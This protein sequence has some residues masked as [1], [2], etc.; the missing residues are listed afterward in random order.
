[1]GNTTTVV[2]TE[3]A[4]GPTQRGRRA[5][6]LVAWCLGAIWAYAA[7]V[8]VITPEGDDRSRRLAWSLAIVIA[9]LG[10]LGVAR[11]AP[12]TLRGASM[13][14]VGFAMIPVLLGAVAERLLR[15]PTLGDV[16]GL[17]AGIAG[18]V[19]IVQ[20][21]RLA[22]GAIRR[23]WVRV[24]AAL[25]G[26]FLVLQF[27]VVPATWAVIATNRA[28][29][30]SS[31]RTLADAGIAYQDVRIDGNGDYA[32]AAWWVP[33]RNRGAVIVLPGSGS[34]RD[35][36]IDHAAVV[37]N[38]GYGALL[39]D[40]AGHGDSDGRLMDFG[41]GS[42]LDVSRA[43]TWVLA[44][45][46][47]ERV[48]LLGLSMGGEVA[49]TTAGEDPRIAAVVAEG[50]TAR[51]WDDVRQLPESN[52]IATANSW[53]EF[54][55]TNLLAGTDP[56]IPLIRAVEQIDA[57][58]LLIAGNAP[59]E[60]SLD[61]RYAAAAP[62]ATLWSLADSGHIQALSTHPD[63]YRQRVLDLFARTLAG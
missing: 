62:D 30:V 10:A 28:R 4:V 33:S 11:R 21:W 39:L 45:P 55:L 16:L 35:D 46:G 3:A 49:L 5:D 24:T 9:S 40:L 25:A 60:E 14:L 38:A 20:G 13:L 29:P 50:A 19:L 44:Q 7:T 6:R 15:S 52:P 18:F 56:P 53:L 51:T 23:R 63:E 12:A 58:V 17:L 26:S 27:L 34:T 59:R 47:V 2:R 43:V 61:T 1:M 22:L 57:P 48:G 32:L 54:R 36:V 41:W 42:N 31:G 8:L 37:A